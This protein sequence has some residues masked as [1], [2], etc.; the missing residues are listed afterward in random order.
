MTSTYQPEDEVLGRLYDHR[1]MRRL[2]AY[3]RP[4][5]LQFVLAAAFMAVW[6]AAQLAGPYLMKVAIDQYI[7]RHDAAGLP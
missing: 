6:S 7:L 1:V 4:Y 2:L 5:T 3:V